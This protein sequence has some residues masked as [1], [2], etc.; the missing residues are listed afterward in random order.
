M[1]ND[2]TK[3]RL[4]QRLND[5]HDWPSVYMFK[6]IFEPQT[7][8]LDSVTALF[9]AEVEILRKYSAGGKYLSLTVREVMMSAEEVVER[10][11][12]ASEIQGVII[13]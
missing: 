7:E 4:R 12:K 1:L 2:E 6:F 5:V 11:N 3:D 10:Y 9:P 13:L 8:R